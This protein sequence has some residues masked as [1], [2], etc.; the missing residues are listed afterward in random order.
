[1]RILDLVKIRKLMDDNHRKFLMKKELKEKEQLKR[2]KR[3]QQQ[4]DSIKN[5]RSGGLKGI[6]GALGLGEFRYWAFY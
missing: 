3:K 4:E 1:M 6:R 5:C 2:E